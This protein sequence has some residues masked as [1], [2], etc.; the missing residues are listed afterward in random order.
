MLMGF[1][2]KFLNESVITSPRIYSMED[3]VF[4]DLWGFLNTHTFSL[5]ITFFEICSTLCEGEGSKY[6]L[7]ELQFNSNT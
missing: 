6:H 4:S 5:E 2:V 1:A 7:E 3:V